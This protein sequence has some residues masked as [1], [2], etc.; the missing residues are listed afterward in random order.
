MSE[1]LND[2]GRCSSCGHLPTDQEETQFLKNYLKGYHRIKV[3]KQEYAWVRKTQN[4][5]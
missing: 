2:T 1:V 4:D 5:I 3:F